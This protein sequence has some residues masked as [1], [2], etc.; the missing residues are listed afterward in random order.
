MSR[1][2]QARATTLCAARE[3]LVKAQV[4]KLPAAR[5]RG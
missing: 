1:L 3:V 2:G 4:A 5:I